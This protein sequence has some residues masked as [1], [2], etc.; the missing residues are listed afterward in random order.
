M[1]KLTRY[2]NKEFFVNAE[3][4]QFVET[5]PDT[6]ITLTSGEKII[7][8]ESAEEVNNLVIRYKQLIHQPPSQ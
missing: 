1:I 3:L 6:I 5:K 2:D 4:I 8:K 7:V